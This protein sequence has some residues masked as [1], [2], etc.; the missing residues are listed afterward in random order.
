MVSPGHSGSP[1]RN[2]FTL[3]ELLVVMTIIS[4]LFAML[5]PA[6]SRAKENARRAVCMNNLRQCGVIFRL[7]GNDNDGWLP[8]GRWGE[9]FCIM[10]VDGILN[11]RYRLT[12][13]LLICPSQSKNNQGGLLGGPYGSYRGPDNGYWPW[14]H[15][16]WTSWGGYM[17]YFYKGGPGDW[18]YPTYPDCISP[19]WY[20]WPLTH[21]P[22]FS[23]GLQPTP[24][25]DMSPNPSKCPVMW[26]ISYDPNNAPMYNTTTGGH[27]WCCPDQSNHP[28][29]DGTAAGENTLYVDGH[30]EWRALA[31]GTGQLWA[32]DYYHRFYQ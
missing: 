8:G 21:F 2:C 25:F 26:D 7:Y 28:N 11:D 22:L 14:D 18:Y 23:Q 15:I 12:S 17:H 1:R 31:N 24:K 9:S 16:A 19:C 6:L 13:N 10:H 20:G 5:L 32:Y 3:I 29:R 4:L 30:V 27:Y